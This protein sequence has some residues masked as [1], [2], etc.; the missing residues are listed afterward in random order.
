M[1]DFFRSENEI[2]EPFFSW[3]LTRLKI[4]R[5]WFAQI[6]IFPMSS[7]LGLT[8]CSIAFSF[9][10]KSNAQ[11][12]LETEQRI[13]HF[14]KK[15]VSYGIVLVLYIWSRLKIWKSWVCRKLKDQ[16]ITFCRKLIERLENL[17]EDKRNF[18]RINWLFVRN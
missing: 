14:K 6:K 11:L 16:N 18:F 17:W 13:L 9:Q 12:Q 10:K 3:F 8:V 4:Q 2:F 15:N 5:N 7:F 1:E